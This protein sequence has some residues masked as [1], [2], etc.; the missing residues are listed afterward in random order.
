MVATIDCTSIILVGSNIEE[1]LR[2]ALKPGITGFSS[3]AEDLVYQ[4]LAQPRKKKNQ[5]SMTMKPG[6]PM[7]HMIIGTATRPSMFFFVAS[8]L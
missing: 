5:R 7:N 1:V 4:R 8:K 2:F 3:E 6:T